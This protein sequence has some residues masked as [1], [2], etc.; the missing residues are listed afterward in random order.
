MSKVRSDS[1][2]AMLVLVTGQP[3]FCTKSY[4]WSGSC[5]GIENTI[6]TLISTMTEK[7]QSAN[8]YQL[9]HIGVAAPVLLMYSEAVANV[10]AGAIL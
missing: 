5:L 9:S 8:E 6:Q 3:T 1:C 2:V 7:N 4:T 10:G